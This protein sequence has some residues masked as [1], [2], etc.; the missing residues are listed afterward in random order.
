MK[1]VVSAALISASFC[2]S[3]IVHAAVTGRGSY[4][5][6]LFVPEVCRVQH[7][8]G[9]TDVG[10]GAYKLGGLNEYCNLPQGY[11]VIVTYAPGT[12]R[13]AT[14]TLG[15]DSIVLNGSGTAVISQASGPRML[16]R[17]LI[18]T[19]GENGFDTDRLN[20]QAVAS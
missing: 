13:G 17:E 16:T 5:L 8:P 6:S 3:P 18:A 20:F 9:L 15:G 10:G 4:A 7:Q 14:L 19:P 12:M 11:T 2:A 1:K